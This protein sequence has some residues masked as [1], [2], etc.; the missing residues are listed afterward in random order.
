MSTLEIYFLGCFY[1]L[2]ASLMY[3]LTLKKFVKNNS[4]QEGHQ[5]ACISIALVYVM[6]LYE[7]LF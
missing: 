6:Y 4:Q 7:P 2:W 1:H 3:C 5:S